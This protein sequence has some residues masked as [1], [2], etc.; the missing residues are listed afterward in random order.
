MVYT[1][2]M[3]RTNI[4]VDETLVRKAR[5]LTGLQ[6]KREI[7]DTALELLVR[8]ETRKG[9]LPYF[10]AGIWKGDLKVMRRNRG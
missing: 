5:K 6:T 7:V 1:F 4:N 8:T 2:F 3:A 9:I 10:G